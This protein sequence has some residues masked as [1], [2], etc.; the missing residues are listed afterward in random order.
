MIIR[1]DSGKFLV[2]PSK[3]K[4]MTF[5]RRLDFETI[6]TESLVK[7]YP[8]SRLSVEFWVIYSTSSQRTQRSPPYKSPSSFLPKMSAIEASV[9][10]CLAE[11]YMSSI[12]LSNRI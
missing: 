6:Q 11:Q 1:V 5:P 9:V 2:S 12:K 4:I 10:R 3:E 8:T 7:A